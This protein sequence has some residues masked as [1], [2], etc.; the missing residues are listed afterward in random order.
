ML[1]TSS[2]QFDERSE[3]GAYLYDWLAALLEEALRP[4]R[5][6]AQEAAPQRQGTVVLKHIKKPLAPQ[7]PNQVVLVLQRPG[8]QS[9]HRG[10]QSLWEQLSEY[11][12]D[13]VSLRSE[14]KLNFPETFLVR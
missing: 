4:V 8:K 13:N 9:E 2:I 5:V 11:M 3:N 12:A 10:S 6:V 1:L 14:G 7:L